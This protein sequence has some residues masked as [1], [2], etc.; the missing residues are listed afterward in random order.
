[1]GMQI[2]LNLPNETYERITKY[3]AYAKREMS[4]VIAAAIDSTLPSPEI[5]Q[6]LQ[7][8]T[9]LSDCELLAQTEAKMERKA[10]RRLS[11]LLERQQAGKLPD[12]EHAELAALMRTYES[13]LLQVSQA[14]AEAV[15]RGLLPPLQS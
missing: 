14:L 10:D 2:T 9:K 1:M 12:S 4:D 6:Q 13:N 5:I 3:A 11:H 15:R 8:I 7:A